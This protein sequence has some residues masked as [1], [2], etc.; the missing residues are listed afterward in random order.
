MGVERATEDVLAM[1]RTVYAALNARDF[2]TVAGMFGETSA[3]DVSR[4]GLGTHAGI[5]AIRRFL[6]DWFGS[7]DAYTVEVEALQDLGGGVVLAVVTQVARQAGSGAVLRVRSAPVFSWAEGRIALVTLYPDIDEGR[8]AALR[9]AGPSSQ[10]SIGLQQA[11]VAAIAAD[12][13]PQHLLAPDFSIESR[14]TPA[15][16]YRYHGAPGLREWA[17]DLFDAFGP[18][19]E[20]RVEEVI[21]AGAGYVVAMFAVVGRA[22]G[23]GEPLE[24]RWPGVMWFEDGRAKRAVGYHSRD[25]A[26]AAVG[27]AEQ[28]G[29]PHE[30]PSP[31]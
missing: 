8:A 28:A 6:E 5:N 11:I 7:L 31:N 23:S 30:A 1:T 4:W 12:E 13:M 9:A 18:G 29:P 15:V 19:A 17:S 22:V 21:A 14:A 10:T 27:L 2:D 26:L 3:W 20:Y 24:L 25:E 16:D